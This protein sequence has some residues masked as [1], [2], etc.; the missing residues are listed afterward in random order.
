MTKRL[1]DNVDKGS[2]GGGEVDPAV[3]CVAAV[4]R[5]RG[6]VTV[7]ADGRAFRTEMAEA[8]RTQASYKMVSYTLR[9]TDPPRM[10]A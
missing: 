4:R 2:D 9:P 5:L 10:C 7:A 8:F 6:H 1:G 3:T